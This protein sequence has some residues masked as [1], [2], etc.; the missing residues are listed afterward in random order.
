MFGSGHA[1]HTRRIPA[2]A[3]LPARLA[4]T[5][6]NS[7]ATN[8]SCVVVPARHPARISAAPIAISFSRKNAGSSPESDSHATHSKC[9][10][11]VTLCAPANPTM[12]GDSIT[13]P[14]QVSAQESADFLADVIAGVS[15]NP[16]TIPCKYFYDKRGAALFQKI[17]EQPEYYVTRTEIDILDR[18]RADI[19]SQ[20]G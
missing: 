11:R 5:T 19:A 15:S 3:L 4:S 12:T 14:S 20:V 10:G 6:A 16:R 7:C 18:S 17:C 2:T 1:A 13:A 9:V 8:T